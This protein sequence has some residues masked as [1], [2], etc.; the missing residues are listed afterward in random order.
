MCKLMFFICFFFYILSGFS[1]I[2]DFVWAKKGEYYTFGITHDAS[3]NV[4][5]TG[6]FFGT[7]DFD[8]SPLGVFNLTAASGRGNTF[9]LKLNA[10]GNFVWAKEFVPLTDQT[11][12]TGFEIKVDPMGNVYTIGSFSNQN[13]SWD[14][15]IVDFDPGPGFYNLET[16]VFPSGWSANSFLSKLDA[17][18]NFVW[19]HKMV[20]TSDVWSNLLSF[21]LD[22]ANN[23]CLTGYFEDTKDFNPGALG[24]F[25]M[26]AVGDN[27]GFMLKLNTSG[28]FMWAKQ[29]GG[30]ESVISK[31]LA[32]DDDN[33]IYSIGHFTGTADFNPSLLGVYNITSAGSFDVYISK[34]NSSGNFVWAKAFGGVNSQSGRSIKIDALN[35]V[36]TNG[37]FEGVTDFDPNPAS[38]FNLTTS[39]DM[40]ISKLDVNGNFVWAKQ[41]ARATNN[42]TIDGLNHIYITGNFVGSYDCDPGPASYLLSSSGGRDFFTLRLNHDGIFQSAFKTG[43]GGSEEATC[44]SMD[45]S[46]N[47]YTAGHF[48]NTVDFNPGPGTLNLVAPAGE[49]NSF[50][51]KL[52]QSTIPL[53][54]SL[55]SFSANCQGNNVDLYWSTATEINNDHF[56]VEQS[57]DGINFK[58]VGI[59]DS[60]GNGIS[61]N[62]YTYTDKN[63]GLSANYYRLNQTDF[64]GNF[65]YSKVIHV[66]CK[67]DDN[68][69]SVYPNPSV[70]GRINIILP[71]DAVV[72][73]MNALGKTIYMQNYP[74]GQ[75][76]INLS[77]DSGTYFIKVLSGSRYQSQKIVIK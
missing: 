32:I 54:V 35:N 40:F 45:A 18:G 4:Y 10:S 70:D 41:L 12:V 62:D 39:T 42:F 73:V 13:Y 6:Y 47:I 64:N 5:T 59:I 11:L 1:Q 22:N 60:K 16:D 2:P 19:A 51:T 49:L 58:A 17:S 9:I 56:S 63:P 50:I 65:S 52:N 57:S 67:D 48:Q 53:P 20:N 29:F 31:D 34:L 7:V 33:N 66:H 76:G 8:P 71:N 68:V 36:I 55:L 23:I 77:P 3:G 38:T 15:G 14:N 28:N 74:L 37:Y 24:I 25:N 30:T 21:E 26:T 27:D 46:N 72:T 61:T 43:G 69:F 44:I 75:H